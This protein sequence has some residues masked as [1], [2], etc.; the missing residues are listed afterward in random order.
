MSVKIYNKDTGKFEVVKT[1]FVHIGPIKKKNKINENNLTYDD[2]L[3]INDIV[4][5]IKYM[6]DEFGVRTVIS[7][8]AVNIFKISD[9]FE[10][11]YGKK[12]I[13]KFRKIEKDKKSDIEMIKKQLGVK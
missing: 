6:A 1:D 12:D 9:D 7:T 10:N 4:N 13:A 8:S 11:E 2:K 3:R 5:K